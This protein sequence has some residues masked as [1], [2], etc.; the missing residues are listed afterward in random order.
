MRVLIIA[1]DL[2]GALDSAVAVAG[3]GLRCAV[4]RRPDDVA[5]ALAGRPDVLGV[6]TASREGGAAAARSAVAAAL[7]A[8]LDAAGELPEILFKK[9]D[10]RLKGH[11]ADELGALAARAG[12]GRALAAPAIPAQGRTVSGG[13]LTGAG[14]AEPVSVAAAVAARGLEIEVPDTVAESDFDAPLAR[15]LA[16]PPA[17][18]VGAAGLAAAL[19]RRLSRHTPAPAP[20]R[21]SPPLLLAIGSHDPITLAQVERLAASRVT[22]L[23]TA[24][25]G[26]CPPLPAGRTALVRLTA[27]AGR[28]FD[29][30]AAGARFAAGIAQLVRTGEVRTLF[31]CGGETADA[32]LGALGVG[33]LHIEGEILPGVPVSRM[34]VDGRGLQLVTKSGGFGSADALVSVVEAADGSLEGET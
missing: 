16:G 13:W 11:V 5:A 2:T 17:V 7:D 3:A 6:S 15:A 4:A 26:A 1:D 30:R 10:S 8:A 31:C 27:V 21:L 34:L 9:V 29:P 24:P 19:A 22:P 32:I 20:L 14:I 28:R 23:A 12:R 33:V 18:L 25:D